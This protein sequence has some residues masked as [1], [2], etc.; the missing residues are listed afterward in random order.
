LISSFTINVT[1]NSKKKIEQ[2][3]AAAPSIEKYCD[4]YLMLQC[5]DSENIVEN[6]EHLIMLLYRIT[7]CIIEG[8]IFKDFDKEKSRVTQG[9]EQFMKNVD[10]CCPEALKSTKVETFVNMIKA[11][12]YS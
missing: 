2:A 12:L 6:W 1:N 11:L 3:K 10:D 7:E 4:I 5:L 9:F 8:K